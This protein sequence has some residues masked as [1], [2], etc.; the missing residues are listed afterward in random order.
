MVL[1][2][3]SNII[4]L[5][6]LPRTSSFQLISQISWVSLKAHFGGRLLFCFCGRT[7]GW[8]TCLMRSSIKYSL[9]IFKSIKRFRLASRREELRLRVSIILIL[10][11]PVAV[12]SYIS[13]KWV[14]LSSSSPTAG[15]PQRQPIIIV[16]AA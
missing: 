13:F 6:T 3:T 12:H 15:T 2:D 5:P 1:S 11:C 8:P 7:D 14:G 10:I 16:R 4:I 9:K